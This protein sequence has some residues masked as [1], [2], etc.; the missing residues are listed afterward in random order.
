MCIRDRHDPHRPFHNSA[1]KAQGKSG[2]ETPK[3]GKLAY[4]QG[5]DAVPAPTRIF[6][7]DEIV[8]PGFLPDLPEIREEIAMYYSSVR[9]A[10]DVV[11][12]VLTE[13][14][15][16]G[17][18]DNTVVM[19]KSDH[20]IAVP[21]AKTNVYRHSTI[22]PWIVRW[23]GKLKPGSHDTEHLVSGIDFAPTILD[24]LGITAMTGMDGRSF[25][26]VLQGQKQD[27]RDYVYTQINAIVTKVD[28]TMRSIQGKRFGLIWNAWSDGK[29][30]FY[31]AA[32]RRGLTWNAMVD[33]ARTNPAVAARVNDFLYRVPF[34]F[35]DYNKDP[36][37]LD[38]LIDDPE[39]KE[40]IQSYW[41][42]L[43]ES[44]RATNDPALTR[45]T[46]AF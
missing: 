6:Q 14:K 30:E 37:A 45:S 33:E 35:Y 28:Y 32:M 19:L 21:F 4:F 34:E 9:R 17:F 29:K 23:P 7:P 46:A 41:S 8:V 10:D 43:T 3:L 38:N 5:M 12:R 40:L 15:A 24:I 1:S 26:P 16:A 42:K 36:D 20:G 22:T 44:M 13:L 18:D 39:S 31:N 27:D 25:L 11:G 2:K